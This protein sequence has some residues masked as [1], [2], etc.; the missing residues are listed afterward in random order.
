MKQENVKALPALSFV[1]AIKKG[2]KNLFYFKGRARRSEFWPFFLL[3]IVLWIIL[4]YIWFKYDINGNKMISAQSISE[5]M[6]F[7]IGSFLLGIFPI[8]LLLS[9]LVR[10]LHDTGH[11]GMLAI[12]GGVAGVLF[13]SAFYANLAYVFL[14]VKNPD[15]YPENDTWG[16][17]VIGITVCIFIVLLIILLY[18]V[19]KDSQKDN[20]K[21]GESPKYKVS[22]TNLE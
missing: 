8:P 16:F 21:Y 18:F 2:F 13:F 9:C 11:G 1:E 7:V 17:G 12:S 19:L 14:S 10:R 5:S 6:L 15:V 20:N 4:N 3:I 22:S